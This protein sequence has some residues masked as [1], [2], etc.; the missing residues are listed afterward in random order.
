[1]DLHLLRIFAKVAEQASFTRAAE[2]LGLPKGRV[3]ACVQT[4]EAQLGTRLLQRTTR[5][6]R[7]TPDGELFLERCQALLADADELQT[8]F[9]HSPSTLRGRLRVDL[10]NMLARNVVIPKLPA[11]LAAHPLLEIEL[12]ATDRRVDLVHEGFDCVVRV[13][14]LA[15]S[16]LV[17]RPVGSMKQI[18]VAS[19]AYL[20]RHG[21]PRTLADLQHHQLIHYTPTLGMPSPGWEF[22]D[23]GRACNQPMGGV[24]TINNTEAYQ[25]ACLAGL[26]LIQ[27]PELGVRALIAQGALTE[28]LPQW[29]A[30]PLPVALVY[31]HRR[32]L[33]K[34]VQAMMDWL[35]EVMQAYLGDARD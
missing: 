8:L 1:M 4:L 28:V 14:S 26:G 21:T 6:V 3:S 32:N 23:G 15:D 11:F 7:V 10:P 35:T 27:V 5:T 16:G 25:A 17:A 31:P 24:M 22:Q 19:P 20:Q 2:Q 29:V 18:N 12:S 34:R 9:Q 30:A 13:G 33:T